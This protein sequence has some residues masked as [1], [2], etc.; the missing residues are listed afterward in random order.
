[1]SIAHR[2][3][4]VRHGETLANAGGYFSGQTDVGLTETGEAQARRAAE[5]IVAFGPD[6]IFSS[7]LTRCQT[8]AKAAA[9]ELGL[10]L[11]TL[12]DLAEM[13]FGVMEGKPFDTLGSLGIS[14]PWPRDDSGASK[15]CERGESF[16]HAYERAGRVLEMVRAGSGR[17]ACVSH[18]ALIRCVVGALLGLEYEAIWNIRL[19]NVASVMLSC[20]NTGKIMLEGIGFAPEEVSYRASHKSLYDPFGVFENKELIDENRD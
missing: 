18:G 19:V 20:S 6:R 9:R 5:A 8:I 13:D 12:D 14:F 2:V 17:T 11:E 4:F 1:M 16:E 15:P 3:L 10:A 7:P